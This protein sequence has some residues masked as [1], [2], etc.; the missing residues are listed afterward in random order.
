MSTWVWCIV[1]SLIRTRRFNVVVSWPSRV[2][3]KFTLLVEVL[4]RKES[5]QDASHIIYPEMIMEQSGNPLTLLLWLLLSKLRLEPGHQGFDASTVSVSL[6][7]SVVRC[8][9]RCATALGQSSPD[10][11][12]ALLPSIHQ[13]AATDQWTSRFSPVLYKRTSCW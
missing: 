10:R 13:P 1:S 5:R 2:S 9:S 11:L 8:I 12:G 3:I 7:L 6:S 4:I